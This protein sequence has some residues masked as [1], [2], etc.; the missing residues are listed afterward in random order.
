MIRV[1]IIEDDPRIAEINRRFVEKTG[2]FEVVGIA[3]DEQQAYE[4]LEILE[5]DLVLLDLHFPRTDG[6][7]LFRYIQTHY[8]LTDVIIITA[9]RDFDTVREAIRRGVYDFMI[10][11]VVFARFQ[12]KLR[13]Y[14]AYHRQLQAMGGPDQ[15]I[16][17]EEIDR[18]LWGTEDRGK[19]KQSY[20]PKGID[21]LTREKIGAFIQECPEVITA[22]EL[23][24]RAGFSRTTA[25]RY[26]EYFVAK[27]EMTSD[28]SYG[29]VGRPER[30]YTR[31]T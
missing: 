5:P 8:P 10:K 19:E 20:F 3:T 2:G 17:Q 22:E 12:E 24:R 7:D 9:T 25:R 27:G 6:L 16:D 11:P 15:V 21:K 1:L 29:T 23:G 13:S 4:H 18:L 28:I 14:E 30:V 31:K 26:L